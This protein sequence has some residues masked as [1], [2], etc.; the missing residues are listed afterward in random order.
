[1]KAPAAQTA[2]A[3]ESGF[4]PEV[5]LVIAAF[6]LDFLAW[7]FIDPFFS[8]F[9][10]DIFQNVLLVGLVFAL[11]GLVALL[12]LGPMSEII[13]RHGGVGISLFARI[14]T[15]VALVLYLIGG[16][17]MSPLVLFLGAII[18]GIGNAGRDVSTREALM[19]SSNQENASTIFG[20]NFSFRNAA[21]MSSAALSGFVLMGLAGF[22]GVAFV[23]IVPIAFLIG[24]C[25]ITASGFLI[26]QRKKTNQT[27]F[28][29]SVLRPDI[30]LQEEKGL[31]QLFWSL[32]APLKFSLILICFLQLI[33]NALLLFLPL[34]A[35]QL[36][37]SPARVG[38]LMATMQIP[39]LFSGM[40]SIFEDRTDRMVFIIG[41]LLFSV[42]PF[43]MLS[44]VDAPLMVAL[45]SVCI[46]LSLAIIH[47]ANLG[48]IAAHTPHAKAPRVAALQIVFQWLGVLLGALALGVIS[49]YF[50]IRVAF[51]ILAALA[52]VF[53]I[54]AVAIKWRFRERP[55]PTKHPFFIHPLHPQV[56]PIQHSA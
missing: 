45:L 52:I 20:A 36:E 30:I 22:A 43:F 18:Q 38:L 42:I 15:V 3:R 14:F 34:L 27:P 11:R 5:K 48:I 28:S 32:A 16:L 46:S 4:S 40:I 9:V 12:S 7:G 1:M 41:G 55:A 23:D 6:S 37:L 33:R 35:F 13:S 44:Q 24:I 39:L 29:W 21:W 51:L 47:P 31:F 10:N 26:H 17:M 49:E 8:V 2:P 19:T 56:A 50:G 53:A 25:C 54:T